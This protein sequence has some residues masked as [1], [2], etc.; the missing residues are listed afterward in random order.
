MIGFD[1]LSER[2]SALV[3]AGRPIHKPPQW[4]SSSHLTHWQ[5]LDFVVDGNSCRCSAG[6]GTAHEEVAFFGGDGK[7]R[8]APEK[9]SLND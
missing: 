9:S 2:A 3:D 1:L 8:S 6:G 7:N 5:L 4:A